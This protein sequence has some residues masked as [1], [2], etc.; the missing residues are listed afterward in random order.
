MQDSPDRE[1]LIRSSRAR[2]VAAAALVSG[3]LVTGCGGGPPGP[4]A[5]S[6]VGF[7]ESPP[8]A[9]STTPATRADIPPAL[10]FS[11][12]MRANGVP[13]FPDP[14]STGNFPVHTGP[15]GVDPLSPAFNA[16]MPKCQKLHPLPGVPTPGQATH[17]SAQALAG[18]RKISECMRQHGV[19]GFPDP[20]TSVSSDAGPAIYRLIVDENGA[21]LAIPY[22]TP[23][24]GPA[25]WQ[26]AAACGI[27]SRKQGD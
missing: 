15:G 1:R 12:C 17:P 16:A 19:S 24:R 11:E 23:Q 21:I 3:L 10:A 5:A 26:A 18:L 22:V 20:R 2:L 13:N 25:Y 6:T 7:T 4:T 9:A 8:A 27:G 14:T